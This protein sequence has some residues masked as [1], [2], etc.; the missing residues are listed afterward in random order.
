MLSRRCRRCLFCPLLVSSARFPF[1]FILCV[2]PSCTRP[3]LGR[4]ASTFI[5]L[6]FWNRRWLP[7]LHW[8][9]GSVTVLTIFG[10]PST[11]SPPFGVETVFIRLFFGRTT[12]WLDW[13]RTTAGPAGQFTFVYRPVS[14]LSP[15]FGGGQGFEIRPLLLIHQQ[16]LFFITGS[17]GRPPWRRKAVLVFVWMLLLVRSKGQVDPDVV[18]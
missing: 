17:A 6:V 15:P 1:A 9:P 4:L 10:N 5:G 12:S 8:P 18:F 3:V 16:H 14:L 7:G 13:H 11:S 2:S